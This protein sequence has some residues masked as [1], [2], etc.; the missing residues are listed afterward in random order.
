MNKFHTHAAH[1]HSLARMGHLQMDFVLQSV[2]FQFS[3]YQSQRQRSSVDGK[4]DLFQKIGQGADVVLVTVGQHNTPDFICIPLCKGEIRQHQINAQ[5]IIC[6]KRQS[7]VHND[8]VVSAFKQCKVFSD[9]IESTQ[10]IYLHGRLLGYLA[11]FPFSGYRLSA[12]LC[13][14]RFFAACRLFSGALFLCSRGS[15]RLLGRKHP[16][17][18]G[19]IHRFCRF[20][21]GSGPTNLLLCC[22][23]NGIR[24]LFYHAIT[25]NLDKQ[26]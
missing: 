15:L 13:S 3:F 24:I 4:V 22:F 8:H 9:L 6:R 17:I 23:F 26:M 7:A 11:V 16:L 2:L 25:S 5:H 19:H 1:F 20:S 21:R 10:K 12:L 14:V 18:Q